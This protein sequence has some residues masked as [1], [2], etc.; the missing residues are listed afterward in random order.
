[1][2]GTHGQNTD[3][4]RVGDRDRIC[5]CLKREEVPSSA[6]WAHLRFGDHPDKWNSYKS[7]REPLRGFRKSNCASVPELACDW[8]QWERWEIHFQDFPNSPRRSVMQICRRPPLTA[9]RKKSGSSHASRSATVRTLSGCDPTISSRYPTKMKATT[10]TG[11]SHETATA[12]TCCRWSF[13]ACPYQ[14]RQPSHVF[15]QPVKALVRFD[16]F[17][18]IWILETRWFAGGQ[19]LLRNPHPFLQSNQLRITLTCVRTEPASETTPANWTATSPSLFGRASYGGALSS[20]S[21]DLKKKFQPDA[22]ELSGPPSEPQPVA[23]PIAATASCVCS[24]DE[25]TPEP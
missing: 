3:K 25:R 14:K 19:A 5:D 12:P 2:S 10:K 24:A 7:A 11:T 22:A 18:G 20:D 16:D 15:G 21:S 23:E 6:T 13:V 8:T 17:P 9:I 1:M 4:W